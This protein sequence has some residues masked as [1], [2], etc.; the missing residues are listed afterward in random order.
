MVD[1]DMED[2]EALVQGM[3]QS[4]ARGDS[5]AVAIADAS[6][7]GRLIGIAA[8]S[9]LER[10]WRSLEP[11]SRTYITLVAP[12]ADA[13]RSADLHLPILEAVRQRDTELAVTALRRHFDLAGAYLR[14]GW[15]GT[16]DRDGAG[17]GTGTGTGT[18]S[19]HRP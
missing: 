11:F 14:E 3:Q 13:Q 4:A 10:V 18:G 16:D 8:N 1:A 15:E 12:G 9:T 6:F 17:T 5:H 7:H 2:L 19:V